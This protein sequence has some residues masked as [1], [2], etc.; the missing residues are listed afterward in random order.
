LIAAPTRKIVKQKMIGLPIGAIRGSV[1]TQACSRFSSNERS[2]M[3]LDFHS[4]ASAQS[5]DNAG[6]G[7]QVDRRERLVTALAA[8]LAVLIV[9]AIAVLM[10]MA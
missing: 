10:G 9:A 2:P 3:P 8:S 6:A 4:A 7:S 1:F 5:S